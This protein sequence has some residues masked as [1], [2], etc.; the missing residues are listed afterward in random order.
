MASLNTLHNSDMPQDGE[1]RI[2]HLGCKPGDVSH[3]I[4]SVGDPARAKLIAEA[5]L[6]PAT[7][8]T[9]FSNRGFHTYTGMYNGVE[10]SI[11]SIGMGRPMMDFMIREARAVVNG[12]MVIIRLGSAG[13]IVT[14]VD[15]GT[16]VV[17]SEGSSL[18]CQGVDAD[19]QF[20]YSFSPLEMPHKGLSD[21]L[22]KEMTSCLS[23]GSV[24]PACDLTAD[25]FYSSQGRPSANFADANAGLLD[26]M[27]AAFPNVGSLQMETY[28]LFRLAN[29][30]LP[31]EGEA[32]RIDTS[33]AAI[34]L[35]NRLTGQGVSADLRRQ[36]EL[37]AGRA[38]LQALANHTF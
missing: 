9:V 16:V 2:Y 37:E 1:G 13:S 12:P 22:V 26:K 38:C 17:N 4:L 30:C 29:I 19:G 18:V 25:S 35:F 20:T 8:R 24:K 21:L 27:A 34:I 11:I 15:P 14:D 33:A 32:N 7:V 10:L 36:L 31:A 23:T 28:Q 6:D 5:Y 3:R